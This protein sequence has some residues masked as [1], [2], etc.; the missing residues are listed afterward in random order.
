MPNALQIKIAQP[1]CHN[2]MALCFKP[3]GQRGKPGILMKFLRVETRSPV[4]E[5]AESL[6]FIRNLF[7]KHLHT[8]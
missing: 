6:Y 8:N 4:T 7:A 3:K 1:L 2:E 5:R